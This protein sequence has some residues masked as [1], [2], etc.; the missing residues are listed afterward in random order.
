MSEDKKDNEY[1]A[2]RC[3]LDD[4]YKFVTAEEI[5]RFREEYANVFRSYKGE[6]GNCIYS[7]EEVR[8]E[9]YEC[10]DDKEL[11]ALIHQG[12]TPEGLA[13]IMSM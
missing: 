4:Y 10:Y 11:A 1:W 13:D 3:K 6:K 5:A 7:E 2:M 12:Q 9:A 8:L